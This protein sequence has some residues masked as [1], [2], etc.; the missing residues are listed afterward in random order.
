MKALLAALLLCV[1]VTGTAEAQQKNKTFPLGVPIKEVIIVCLSSLAAE[2]IAFAMSVG[3]KTTA[4]R[5]YEKFFA[6]GACGQV[7][8]TVVYTRKTANFKQ[9][10]VYEALMG[11]TPAYVITDWKHEPGEYI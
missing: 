4:Q 3:N 6:G 2:N 5:L 11:E 1:L 10:N 8:W 7:G 9:W